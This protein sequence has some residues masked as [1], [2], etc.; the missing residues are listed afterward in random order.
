MSLTYNGKTRTIPNR[1]VKSAPLT[2]LQSVTSI[3]NNFVFFGCWN[4]I[5]CKDKNVLNVRDTL[6]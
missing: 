6:L 5:N 2:S 4:N 1:K 3:K